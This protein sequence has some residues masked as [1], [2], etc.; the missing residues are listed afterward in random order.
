MFNQFNGTPKQIGI[1]YGKAFAPEIVNNLKALVL[2]QSSDALP[3]SDAGFKAWVQRQEKLIEANWPWLLEEMEGVAEGVAVKYE[4]I[5]LLNLRAWQYNYY[6]AEPSGGCSSLVVTL[7]DGTVACAGALDDPAQFYCGPVKF[8]PDTGYAL[9]SFPITGTS[10]GNR[11]MNR[12]GL[13]ASISSQILPGLIRLPNAVNQ[14]LALRAILQTCATINEVRQFCHRHPF[15]MN[16]ICV[17]AKG[18]IFCGQHTSAGLLELPVAEGFCALTN[19][20]VDDGFR[21][22]LAQRGVKEFPESATT[23]LRRGRLL[24]FARERNGKCVAEEVRRFIFHRDDGDLG[25]IHNKG[26]I[27]M[28]FSNPQAARNTC[29]VSG[30]GECANADGF[31]AMTV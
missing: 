1:E 16:L 9:L 26:T 14:D 30:G 18:G 25:T 10:W 2:A 22:W 12:A 24:S 13:V 3:S 11:G 19:H 5:L 31:E 17:D 6:G 15:I 4:D 23:R 8:T 27:Y 29:W 21:Y 28:T 20:V 7:A